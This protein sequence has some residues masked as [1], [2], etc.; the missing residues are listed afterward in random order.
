MDA[1]NFAGFGGYRNPTAQKL[2]GILCGVPAGEGLAI[3]NLGRFA[4]D[5]E[6]FSVEAMWFVPPLFAS[7]D[8]IVGVFTLNDEM[9]YSL[10]YSAAE[11]EEASVIKIFEEAKARLLH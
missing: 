3:S 9:N 11:L 7:S 1:V 4:M 6:R 2:C 10:R 8:L 5:F